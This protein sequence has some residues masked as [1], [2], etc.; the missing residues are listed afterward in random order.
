MCVPVTESVCQCVAVAACLLACA[1][2]RVSE[3]V[4]LGKYGI[5]TWCSS[6]PKGA[7]FKHNSVSF[8]VG[9]CD[10]RYNC[11]VSG[12][13]SQRVGLGLSLQSAAVGGA[14]RSGHQLCMDIL[15]SHLPIP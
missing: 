6:V 8:S 14:D 4:S 1:C 5:Q 3:C 15:L 2:V 11:D 12:Y 7:Y 10:L 9:A 13:G